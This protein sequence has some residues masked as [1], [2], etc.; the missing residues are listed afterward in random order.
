MW[1]RGP[2]GLVGQ[3]PPEVRLRRLDG[4]PRGV[5]PLRSTAKAVAGAAGG[6]G[7]GALG[8]GLPPGA[9]PGAAVRGALVDG[10][11]DHACEP[12]ES[13]GTDD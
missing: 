1:G 5:R 10:S 6:T 11:R 12:A 2:A 7:G 13:A 8:T 4:D 3:D 9:V